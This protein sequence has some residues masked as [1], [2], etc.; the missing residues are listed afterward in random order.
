MIIKIVPEKVEGLGQKEIVMLSK[1]LNVYNGAAT[2]NAQKERYYEG[3]IPLSE[4]N[5]GI[6]LPIGLTGLEIGCAWGAKTVD[7]LARRSMF[8]GFVGENGEEVSELTEIIRD[9]DLIAEY[10]KT[11]RDELKIGCSFH[12]HFHFLLLHLLMLHT[13][14]IFHQ[15]FRFLLHLHFCLF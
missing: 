5:L 1:L 11:T 14:L 10:P 2:K 8:D 6:A 12:L 13:L 3:K 9:N 4:V 15:P 7:V